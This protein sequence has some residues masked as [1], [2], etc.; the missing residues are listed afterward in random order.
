MSGVLAVSSV[1]A[2]VY[3]AVYWRL[4]LAPDDRIRYT[5]SLRRLTAV[6]AVAS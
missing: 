6:P 1:V 4:G 5:A 3:A 2:L